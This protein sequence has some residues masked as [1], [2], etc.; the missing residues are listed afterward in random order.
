MNLLQSDFYFRIMLLFSTIGLFI[1][2]DNDFEVPLLK[3]SQSEVV[4]SLATSD[5]IVYVRVNEET[6]PVYLSIPK[7]CTSESLP[8][9]VLLHGSDGMWKNHD[10]ETGTMA[11]QNSEWRDLFD[12]TCMVGA[13][14]DSYTTRDCTTRTGKWKTPPENFK[15]SSQFIR[16]KDA[17]ATLA[18]LRNLKYENGTK[19]IRPNDIG[20]L[21][22][23]DG[24]SA[25]AST[26][27]DTNA[28]PSG[29]AW[30]QT[31]DDKNYNTS[32]GV[33][34]PVSPPKEGGFSGG[35]FYYGGSGGYNYWG[36]SPCG[37][38]AQNGNIYAPY[39]PLLYQIPENGYLTENTICLYELLKSKGLPVELN[40]YKDV[41]HGFDFDGVEQSSAARKNTINW[42]K[43]I[44]NA[45]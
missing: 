34:P 41:G 11:G 10:P 30:A 18:L 20:L 23:S 35:V 43:K 22:F 37:N 16:P 32:S 13:Y 3:T 28:V 27:F 8:A 14:V 29:W 42:L 2:C 40:L 9:V 39:A 36:T 4:I 26:L 1:S 21:G 6:I 25:V 19:V 5:T 44:L 12:S 31:F 33:L 7:D 38:N 45:N 15:I 24:A 17:Y